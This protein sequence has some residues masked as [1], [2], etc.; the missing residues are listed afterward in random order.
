MLDEQVA[1]KLRSEWQGEPWLGAENFRLKNSAKAL[2]KGGGRR[3]VWD[4][5]REGRSGQ[6][7]Q[8]FVIQGKGLGFSL[9]ATGSYWRAFCRGGG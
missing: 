1:F 8:G 3:V 2:R 6:I 7:A 5:V 9:Y 4:E